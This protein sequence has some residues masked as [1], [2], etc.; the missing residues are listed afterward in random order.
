MALIDRIKFDA[1]SDDLFVWKYPSEE[2]RLGAQLIVN[3]AQEVL[4]VKGG[5]A[6]DVFGPGTHT[7]STDNIPLIRRLIN[8]PFGGK[9]P[10]TAEVWY[11]NKTVKR[12]LKWGTTSPI[13]IIDPLYNYP[14]SVRAFGRW[15]LRIEDSRS[16]IAQV[17]GTLRTAD[18][19]KI[20]AYFV[21]E[22]VQRLSD[23]LGKF[24][25][26]QRSSIFHANAR[27]ND[28]SA[29]AQEAMKNEF[30]RF[31]IEVV[32]F[33]IQRV[34]IPDEDQKKFQEVLGKRMEIEQISQAQVGQ[35]YVT[36]RS[37][38]TLEKAAENEGG[39]AGALLAGGLGLGMGLGAGVPVGQQIG[40]AMSPK[41]SQPSGP[42][43][44]QPGA[45]A[46]PMAKLQQLKQLLDA[47]LIS[48]ED[49]EAKKKQ[50]L[51]SI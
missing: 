25:V 35:A 47:G 32:N 42:S 3:Q 49:F 19:A 31:G 15:G 36:M 17:V 24:F 39:G 6:L 41:A 38:D 2:I 13:P 48:A 51:D 33:N 14:V 45:P 43:Q 11:V 27:L 44:Q 5:Q 30:G 16:F 37:F 7:L 18:S 8:V 22:I 28:L 23:V 9:T 21:G 50:V 46:D 1:P 26:D 12:D 10:F 4:L 29:A 20:E 40:Q 34:S